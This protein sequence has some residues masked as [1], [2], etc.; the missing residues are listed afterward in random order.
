MTFIQWEKFYMMKSLKGSEFWGLFLAPRCAEMKVK[1]TWD[2]LKRNVNLSKKVSHDHSCT[3]KIGGKY[4]QN[5]SQVHEWTSE[6]DVH[7]CPALVSTYFSID[8]CLLMLTLA[9]L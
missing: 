3:F 1:W 2:E 9:L 8:T 4:E 5:M 6:R 7:V